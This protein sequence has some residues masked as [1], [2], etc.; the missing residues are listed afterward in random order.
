[1]A[2]ID[3]ILSA[4]SPTQRDAIRALI[5]QEAAKN[6]PPAPR[7][8]TEQEKAALYIAQARAVFGGENSRLAVGDVVLHDKELTLLEMLVSKVYPAEIPN[9]D[10]TVTEGSAV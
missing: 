7:V 8:L 3:A 5:A 6:V 10:G 1:M 4:F 9:A 2:D